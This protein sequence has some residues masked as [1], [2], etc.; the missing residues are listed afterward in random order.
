MFCQ[1]CNFLL[2]LE[3]ILGMYICGGRFPYGPVQLI[4]T[5]LCVADQLVARQMDSSF[6]QCTHENAYMD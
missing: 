2:K 5:V 1:V 4:T 6:V 3:I